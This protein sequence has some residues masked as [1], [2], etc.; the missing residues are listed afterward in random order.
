[1]YVGMHVLIQYDLRELVPYVRSGFVTRVLRRE[2]GL[3][4]H[5]HHHLAIYLYFSFIHGE[6]TFLNIAYPPLFAL[7]Y[8]GA[9]WTV[10]QAFLPGHLR[11]LLEIGSRCEGL[12]H[13]Q[14][15]VTLSVVCSHGSQG[16]KQER[17]SN[18]V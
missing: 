18:E 13:V 1:M 15:D 4:Y 16:G 12:G 6:D 7:L 11:I 14:L 2:P 3:I 8:A 10:R 9:N 5:H 17:F